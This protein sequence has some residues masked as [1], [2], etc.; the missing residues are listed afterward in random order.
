MRLK[1]ARV[2]SYRSIRDS[3]LVEIE[4]GKTILVG[5]NEA[6]KTVFL[7][8][9]QQVN[10]PTGVP[11]FD[12]LRDYPRSEY[13]DI[14]TGRIA[15]KDVTVV[16]AHFTLDDED[17]AL[18]PTEFQNCTYVS[19]RRLDN[20]TWRRLDNAPPRIKFK[21]IQKDLIRLA[22]HADARVPPPQEGTAAPAAPS[23]RLD[24]ATSGFDNDTQI[25]GDTATKVTNWLKETLPHVD[26]NNSAEISR[27]DRLEGLAGQ[28]DARDK[29]LQILDGRIPIFVLFSNYFRVKPIIHLEHLAQR[30]EGNILDDVYYDYGNK[31]LLQLLG[32]TARELPLSEKRPS[33]LVEMRQH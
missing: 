11:G 32:F 14:T 23:A 7:Q 33:L 6:G 25:G 30:I 13:N 3:G 31:C 22:A 26:E 5:P 15:P 8:A 20:T 12:A 18:L 17:R 28:S 29:V 9:L 4:S 2:R 27:Y 1:A 24:S 10:P 19:G 21:D 16:E